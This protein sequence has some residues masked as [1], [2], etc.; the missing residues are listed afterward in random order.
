MWERGMPGPLVFLDVLVRHHH[1]VDEEEREQHRAP[2][3]K[4]G[5]VLAQVEQR[6]ARKKEEHVD[7]RDVEYQHDEL[8]RLGRSEEHTSELQS[9]AY[10]VC[11]LLLEKK[12]KKIKFT[13]T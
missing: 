4:D 8:R 3:R 1:H 10:L 9:L 11:R 2:Q 13:T 7:Q 5:E 6:H 12:K